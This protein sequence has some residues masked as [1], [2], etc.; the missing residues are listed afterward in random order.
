[1]KKTIATH[2]K[3]LSKLFQIAAILL[4]TSL[5]SQANHSISGNAADSSIEGRWDMTISVDG[6]EEP[7]WLEIKHSGTHRLIGHFVGSG[8]SAR[9]ISKI[10]YSG[11]KMSFTIPPQWEKEDADLS[12]EASLKGD[13]LTGTMIAAD[14]KSYTWTAMRAP[15]LR[16]TKAPV[17]GAPIRLFNGKDMT[18]W[19]TNGPNQWIV[20]NGVLRSPKSGSNLVSDKTFSDFK[21]HIEFR[22]PKGSN[23]GVYL[24]GRYEVQIADTKGM[25]P[26][27]DY[28]GGVYGFL[29][30]REMVAKNPGEWQSFD[31][32]LVGRIVTVKANGKLIIND[33]EIPG[34][35][36]GALDSKEG[37]PGPLQI[38]GDHGAVELRNIIITPAIN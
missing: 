11:G 25:E 19:H 3:K 32:T 26:L 16:R 10:T 4:V 13:Q 22:Y 30:P 1:M 35:T 29:A 2:L 36:G 23:S 8:G 15:S 24:R 12:F 37:E 7:S 21:L 27:S 31:I 20:E 9:P 6:K 34:I 5:A 14:G 38:Q 28:L 18:G 17:W 33:A